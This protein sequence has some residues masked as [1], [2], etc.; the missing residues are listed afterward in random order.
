MAGDVGEGLGRPPAVDWTGKATTSVNNQGQ[1]GCVG[2]VSTA[3][4]TNT[5]NKSL[6]S[7]IVQSQPP[8]THPPNSSCWAFS[9]TQQV[10]SAWIM[11]GHA[12]WRL[13]VQ[14]ATSCTSGVFGCG[15]GDTIQG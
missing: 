6:G 1:C 4:P 11:A 8:N 7:S 2:V 12:P 9:L 10:E 3:L 13:S 5:P 14:Q 15:G